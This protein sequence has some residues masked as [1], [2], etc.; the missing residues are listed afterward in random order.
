L[1]ATL[2]TYATAIYAVDASSAIAPALAS[3]M[4]EQ[5]AK[6]GNKPPQ[7]PRELVGHHIQP[8]ATLP[9]VQGAFERMK[10]ISQLTPRGG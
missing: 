5:I 6:L 10:N 9:T 3:C 1:L 2:M 8:R 4:H 7:Q